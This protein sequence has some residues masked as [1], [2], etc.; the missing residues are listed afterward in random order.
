M[1]NHELLCNHLAP[2]LKGRPRGRRRKSEST[3]FHMQDDSVESD[4]NDSDASVCSYTPKVINY[5]TKLL[6]L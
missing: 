6:L 3:N 1:E 4:S 2:K 5:K